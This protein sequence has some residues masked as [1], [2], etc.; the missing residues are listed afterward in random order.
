MKSSRIAQ[1]Y[2]RAIYQS[3]ADAGILSQVAEDLRLVSETWQTS[4]E[5]R[6]FLQHPELSADA[7][8]MAVRRIFADRIHPV[9][10]NFL[11]VLLD[12][13]RESAIGGIAGDFQQ[14]WDQARGIAHAMVET[15]APLSAED[16]AQLVK[17][18]S[19]VTGQTVVVETRTNPALL[20]GI[21][22]R[23]GDR[24]FDASLVRQL[25]R[26]GGRLRG[27]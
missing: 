10:A 5:F 6:Q 14:L 9:T 7:K 1:I 25:A 27:A 15:A 21:V 20:G 19:R 16:T 18:L 13:G 26:L 2:A 24:V 17:K 8:K 11:D 3:A 22:V 23:I 4:P 12:R